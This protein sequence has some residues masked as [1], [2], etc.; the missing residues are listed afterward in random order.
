MPTQKQIVRFPPGAPVF[1]D[2]PFD[3]NIRATVDGFARRGFCPSGW[4]EIENAD[5]RLY[6]LFHQSRPYLAGIAD[7]EGFSWL[8]LSEL[9][10]KM[11]QIQEAHCSLFACELVQVLLM[12]VHFRHRPNLQASTRLVDLGH[13]LSVLQQDGQDAAMALERGGLRTM[14][15]MQKGV[16]TRL[17]FCDPRDDPGK[18]SV[19]DRFLEY[20]FAP[21]APEGR[22][23]VFHRLKLETDPDAGKSLT[24]LELEAQPPPAVNCKVL[25]G[26]QVVLQRSFMPPAMFIGRDPTCELRLDNL[27]VSR[28]HARI[29]WERGRFVLQDLN[30]SNGT[31]VN[32]KPVD[33]RDVGLDDVITVGKYHIRIAVPEAMPLPQ[34]TVMVSAAGPGSGQ[35]FLVCGEQS[36]ELKH[37]ITIGRV[38]GVD[39]RLRGFGI[40]P[41]HARLHNTDEGSV[42][43]DCVE[44]A[45]V[46][47]NGARVRS[48]L[49]KPGQ[50]FAIGRHSLS[51]VD[52]PRYVPAPQA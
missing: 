49:L 18:G 14:M 6:C 41:I 17:Y 27:S 38:D 44:K 13:V 37:D 36:V 42:R 22:V 40:K 16:P 15:F 19:T 23:E 12:A 47:V 8:P 39:L 28:R 26:E 9:V 31:L 21:G 3:D 20:G 2:R 32:G 11:R 45:W 30:S 7:I 10:P 43:L 35:L 29:G 50:A 25:L 34:A 5:S 4:L 46:R 52:V 48:T 1:S 33:R 51:L 24:Q